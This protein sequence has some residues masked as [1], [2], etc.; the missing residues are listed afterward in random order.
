M[1]LATAP[2]IHLLG[3]ATLGFIF[4][5]VDHAR[6]YRAYGLQIV[7]GTA[8]KIPSG[9]DFTIIASLCTMQDLTGVGNV[10]HAQ[11]KD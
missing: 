5:A 1:T 9:P 6:V 7:R 10:S 3:C 11:S 4:A 8:A 2:A